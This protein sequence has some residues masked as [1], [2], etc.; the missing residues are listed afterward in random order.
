MEFSKDDWIIFGMVL[1]LIALGSLALFG[2]TG[3]R[4][5]L[6]M[7]VIMFFPFYLILSNFS[8]APGE[9]I[10]FALFAGITLFPSLVYF[11]GFVMSFKLSIFLVFGVLAGVGIL[12]S[13]INRQPLI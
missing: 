7:S 2:F 5:A 3:L 4:A 11:L 8:L 10:F 13:R 1:A 12:L 6:G 9:K